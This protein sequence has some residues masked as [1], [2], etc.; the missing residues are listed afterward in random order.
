MSSTTRIVNYG[1]QGF[2]RNIWLSLIAIVTM[3]LTI[4]T[5]TVFAVA[6]LAATQKYKEINAKLDYNIFIKDSAS[7]AEVSSLQDAVKSRPEVSKLDY[8][9]KSRALEL[10]DANPLLSSDARAAI[11]ADNNPLPREI[12]VR[13]ADPNKIAGFNSFV[14]GD[15]FKAIIDR[16]SYQNNQE[17]ISGYLKLVNFLRV[18]GIGFTIFFLLIAV[19][20][21]LN[22]I[23]LTIFSRRD[24]IEVMRLVGATSSFIRGPFLIEGMLFGLIGALVAALLSWFSLY[25]VQHLL[26]LGFAATTIQTLVSGLGYLTDQAQFNR[27]FAQLF[28]VQLLIGVGLGTICSAIAIRRYLRE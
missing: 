6:N 8:I 26:S 15:Q 1:I 19:V 28:A 17:A 2:R 18:F 12:D 21:I 11:S 7:D 3:T 23:R 9:S 27:L 13:F 24:E 4:V 22:T 16:T 25:Q 14:N 20:V 10:F 5:V